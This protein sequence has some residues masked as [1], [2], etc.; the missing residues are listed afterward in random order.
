M[1]T[2]ERKPTD[3]GWLFGVRGAHTPEK[4]TSEG[5]RGC[6]HFKTSLGAEEEAG[7]LIY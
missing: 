3:S 7:Q 1:C 2:S 4:M 5:L 6:E